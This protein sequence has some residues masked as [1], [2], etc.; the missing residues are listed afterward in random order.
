MTQLIAESIE[1]FRI[2]LDTLER[3]QAAAEAKHVQL[4]VTVS[5]HQ[6]TVDATRNQTTQLTSRVLDL[7]DQIVDYNTEGPPC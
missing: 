6:A 3:R 7:E 5:E 4:A 1:E 2:R